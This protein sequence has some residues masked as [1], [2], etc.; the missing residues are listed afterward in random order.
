M[1][2]DGARGMSMGVGRGVS[3]GGRPLDYRGS[4]GWAARIISKSLTAGVYV[5]GVFL[6]VFEINLEAVGSYMSGDEFAIGEH[7]FEKWV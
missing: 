3:P 4:E 2:G 5:A 6:L 7:C 1:G